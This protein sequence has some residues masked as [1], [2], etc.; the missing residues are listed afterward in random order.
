MTQRLVDTELY[1]NGRLSQ[2]SFIFSFYSLT[3]CFDP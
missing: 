1:Y 3:T 2:Q